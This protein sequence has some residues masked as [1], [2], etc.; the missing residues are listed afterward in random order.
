VRREKKDGKVRQRCLAESAREKE[1]KPISLS[2]ILLFVKSVFFFL[3][4]FNNVLYIR[5]FCVQKNTLLE[6][7]VLVSSLT[8]IVSGVGFGSF[9]PV[10]IVIPKK[11]S[12]KRVFNIIQYSFHMI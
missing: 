7:V 11:N 9:Q 12:I 2:F 10:L 8:I 4:N 1:K 5:L 6:R 3:F